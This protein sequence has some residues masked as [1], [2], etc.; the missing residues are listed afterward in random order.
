[1]ALLGEIGK[2]FDHFS[3]MTC[4]DVAIPDA[5]GQ[6][7]YDEENGVSYYF[8]GTQGMPGLPYLPEEY[9]R[10][11]RC[12]GIV[13]TVG[14]IFPAIMEDMSLAA[15]CPVLDVWDYSYGFEDAPDQG[16]L[17]LDWEG[18]T[19]WIDTDNPVAESYDPTAVGV[20]VDDV[21]LIVD[22]AREKENYQICEEY[23]NE[24]IMAEL[25]EL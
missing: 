22:E 10:R 9:T 25:R 23:W 11:L 19:V 1:M 4:G 13:S 20:D 24:I 16:W 3:D 15:F 2:T 14:A 6:C 21:I 12:A 5:S 8:F 18:Y 17:R 7:M